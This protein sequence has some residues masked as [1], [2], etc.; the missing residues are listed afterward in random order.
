MASRVT[1][2]IGLGSG[3]VLAS[4]ANQVQFRTTRRTRFGYGY[5]RGLGLGCGA[6]MDPTRQ[7]SRAY[8][9]RCAIH[10]A[11]V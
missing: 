7:A 9:T 5:V 1:N 3:L 8:T 10:T 11:S 2:F 4:Q 6:K